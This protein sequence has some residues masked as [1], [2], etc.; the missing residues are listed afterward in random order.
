MFKIPD[1]KLLVTCCNINGG[2]YFI[3][4]KNNIFKQRKIFDMNFRG[5]ARYKDKFV[6]VSMN[7]ITILDNYFNVCKQVKL[8]GMYDGHGV[9]V[10]GIMLM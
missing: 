7:E 9:A 8:E 1:C 10:C 2:L 3:E 6:L 4:F 5:I